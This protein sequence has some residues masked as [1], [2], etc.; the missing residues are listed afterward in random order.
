[1][2]REGGGR[3]VLCC[4]NQTKLAG[5]VGGRRGEEG[6]GEKEEGERLSATATGQ[7]SG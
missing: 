7:V 6:R 3:D 1:M 5:E 4:N 2:K